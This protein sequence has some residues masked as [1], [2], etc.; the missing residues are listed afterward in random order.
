[1]DAAAWRARFAV[2]AEVR[3]RAERD[4]LWSRI[5]RD[6]ASAIVAPTNR[7]VVLEPAREVESDSCSVAAAR[8]AL[9]VALG[10]G[11]AARLTRAVAAVPRSGVLESYALRARRHDERLWATWWGGAFNSAG[12]WSRGGFEVL[13]GERM[14]LAP[15]AVVPVDAMTVGQIKALAIERGIRIPSKYAKAAVIEHVKA[16]GLV[17][18]LPPPRVRGVLDALEG[19]QLTRHL[20]GAATEGG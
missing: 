8:R 19:I 13:G 9:S 16:L 15:P 2:E 6:L 17:A 1:M 12:Y 18:S 5:Q 10:A 20:V 14:S 11:W 7:P 3:Y 4:A